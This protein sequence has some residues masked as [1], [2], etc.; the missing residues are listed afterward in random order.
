MEIYMHR[1][2]DKLI[3]RKGRNPHVGGHADVAELPNVAHASE[4][5]KTIDRL[6]RC[7]NRDL[8][9]QLAVRDEEMRATMRTVNNLASK[10]ASLKAFGWQKN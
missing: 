8:N 9:A 6:S 1:H 3:E 2:D 4:L 5:A 7:Q 10:N